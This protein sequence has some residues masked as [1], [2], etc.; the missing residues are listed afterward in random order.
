LETS[1]YPPV[2]RFLENLGF[3]VKGEIN[4]CDVVARRQD[5]PLIVAPLSGRQV[6]T[7]MMT[8]AKDQAPH[9]DVT[10]GDASYAFGGMKCESA[11]GLTPDQRRTMPLLSERYITEFVSITSVQVGWTPKG[12][13]VKA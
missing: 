6:N 5:S 8:A 11:R 10:L 2:K 9:S 12:V 4:G 3:E 7:A 1:L 13:K